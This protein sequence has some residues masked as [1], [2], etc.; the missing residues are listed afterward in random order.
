M[1]ASKL[2]A[3]DFIEDLTSPYARR[4]F[5][6]SFVA[7]LLVSIGCMALATMLLNQGWPRDL[8]Q[9][10]FSEVAAASAIILIFYAVYLYFIGP[11]TSADKVVVVRSQDIR[12][13][14]RELVNE[15]R[16]YAFWGRTGA[17][18]RS[19]SLRDLSQQAIG[20]R[21]QISVD[22]LLPDPNDPELAAGYSRILHALGE[23][24]KKPTLPAHVL[25]TC[26]VCAVEE[27]NNMHLDVHVYLS[28]HLPTYRLDLSDK[29]VLLTQDDRR[30]AAL[31]FESEGEFFDL[32]RAAIDSEK[33]RSREVKWDRE[34]FEGVDL[35]TANCTPDQLASLN[36]GVED[37]D[38]VANE[39]GDLVRN[40]SHRYG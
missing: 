2:R 1:K 39:V 22:V 26:F 12:E 10:F 36:V 4:R 31:R 29:G 5:L 20:N 25:A 33:E 28:K 24:A 34:R 38:G 23:D 40:R 9:S 27:A 32:W 6:W 37:H 14:L 30:R 15:T 11:H 17:F 18:F 7:I 13:L 19:E 21:R 35:A 3:V 8:L 16:H